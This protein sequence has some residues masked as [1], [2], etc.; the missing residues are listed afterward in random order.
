M[1]RWREGWPAGLIVLAAENRS[2]ALSDTNVLV[3]N[4]LTTDPATISYNLSNVYFTI[5]R[6]QLIREWYPTSALFLERGGEIE[7][8]LSLWW[9]YQGSVIP[10]TYAGQKGTPTGTALTGGNATQTVNFSLGSQSI[11][12]LIGCFLTVPDSTRPFLCRYENNPQMLEGYLASSGKGGGFKRPGAFVQDYAFTFNNSQ[13]SEWPE[14]KRSCTCS[15][16]WD[17]RKTQLRGPRLA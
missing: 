16:S 1:S 12:L 9:A 17:L 5:S 3:C 6:L 8:K 7:R 15:S 13:P 10:G 11:D 4:E 14:M 2:V